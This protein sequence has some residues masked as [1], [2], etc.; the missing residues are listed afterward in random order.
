MELEVNVMRK[1]KKKRDQ[2][3]Q[4]LCSMCRYQN[5]TKLPIYNSND[6]W[7]HRKNITWT[8]LCCANVVSPLCCCCWKPV[9]ALGRD[10]AV[11]GRSFNVSATIWS[12]FLSTDEHEHPHSSSQHFADFF[13]W[14]G[15]FRRCFEGFLDQNS[16][17]LIRN[18]DTP[19]CRPP[20]DSQLSSSAVGR[21]RVGSS[22]WTKARSRLGEKCVRIETAVCL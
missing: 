6:P 13:H 3:M 4:Q 7:F 21:S 18:L 1:F 14:R 9:R 2:G 5:A 17:N 22:R 19:L 15:E 10:N 12:R 20:R 11:G 8:S 16:G